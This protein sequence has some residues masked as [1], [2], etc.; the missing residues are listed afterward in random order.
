MNNPWFRLYTE[1][2]DDEKLRLLAF[3]DRWHFIAILCCKGK[4]IIDEPNKDLMRRK[5]A[6]KLGLDP[7]ALDEVARRL[8]EVGLIDDKTLQPVAWD[9]R[10]FNSDHDSTA[11][12]RK[13]RQ[14]SIQRQSQ[15]VTDKSRVTS[16]DVTLL[17]T[18]ADT[19]TDTDT[20]TEAET[21]SVKQE[22]VV[23]KKG[24]GARNAPDAT[25][26]PT[27]KPQ[28]APTK[29]ATLPEIPDWL[30]ANTWQAFI[31]YRKA[32]RKPLTPQAAA[33]TL[34]D[35]DKARAFGHDPVALIEAA[36]AN[37]WTGCVFRDRHF[38]PL[39]PANSPAVPGG[40]R[41]P[42]R[43]V[44]PLTPEAAEFD[45]ILQNLHRPVLDGEVL[46]ARH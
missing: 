41:A 11:T 44:S 18:E 32:K 1:A 13:R 14:R 23:G 6:V 15:H 25:A 17:D 20:D 46:N 39:T 3:E 12:E 37:G 33:L 26:Q 34:R 5:V 42:V 22:A 9:K 21:E 28:S 8:A 40:G 36:I 31:D 43:A 4:G 16:H 38:Q 27:T 29:A 7:R 24:V 30:P 19:D 2:V 35:L 45:A 10:Q